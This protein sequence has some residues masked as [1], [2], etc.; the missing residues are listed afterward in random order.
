MRLDPETTPQPD[1]DP[2]DLIDGLSEELA[3]L[4]RAL[5]EDAARL[6]D[7]YAADHGLSATCAALEPLASVSKRARSVVPRSWRAAA[8]VA[9]V[10]ASTALATYLGQNFVGQHE[11]PLADQG[12][13]RGLVHSVRSPTA[14][15]VV[16]LVPSARTDELLPLR[17]AFFRELSSPQQEAVLDLLEDDALAQGSA[18]I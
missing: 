5:T 18:S 9:A 14:A 10:A 2:S 8:A 1:A 17:G 4:A 11:A 12:P 15:G 3:L 16:Q 6:A 13:A 7:R